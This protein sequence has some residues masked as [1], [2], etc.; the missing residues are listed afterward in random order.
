MPKLD[1]KEAFDTVL[2]RELIY[3]P[4]QTKKT[5]WAGKAAEA[6]YNVI[7]LMGDGHYQVLRNIEQEAQSRVTILNTADKVTSPQFGHTVATVLKAAEPLIWN[8]TK[9]EQLFRTLYDEDDY[10]FLDVRK[11]DSNF[12]LVLDGWTSFVDSILWDFA[13]E[14][15]IDLSDGSKQ[16]W[17]LYGPCNRLA[18]WTL[19]QLK[20]L[21]C[22]VIV[23]GHSTMWEK[24]RGG[25]NKAT[26]N[27]IIETRQQII[28]TSGNHS[29]LLPGHFS[30]T[31]LFGITGNNHNWIDS[32]P[33]GDRDSGSRTLVKL[34]DWADMQFK[35][36]AEASGCITPDPE[37][38][39]ECEGLQFYIGETLPQEYKPKKR[40]NLA[41]NSGK[42][43][44]VVAS[45]ATG[46]P[47]KGLAAIVQKKKTEAR[48]K[49][50]FMFQRK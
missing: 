1:S 49:S 3:G 33:Q 13:N 39:K 6:G 22:H 43:A 46:K 24:R 45:V 29:K 34:G 4:S 11:L 15:N 40:A 16:E 41:L 38:A 30:E 23:I 42:G 44:T 18:T 12:I 26:K 7:F 5:F 8:D 47:A 32:R 37:A 19:Q 27:D 20:G 17:E 35:H 14:Q 28:S 48:P 31:L 36:F 21:P 10:I 2:L 50:T 9:N 25:K